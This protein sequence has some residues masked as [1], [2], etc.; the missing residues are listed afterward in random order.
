MKI[1]MIDVLKHILSKLFSARFIVVLALTTTFCVI[2]VKELVSTE[3]YIAVLMLVLKYYFEDKKRPED[4]N[5][6]R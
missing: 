3:A 5:G 1:T 4:N 2:T 6:S